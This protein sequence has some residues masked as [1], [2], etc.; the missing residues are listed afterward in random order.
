MASGL[1]D[2]ITESHTGAVATAAALRCG[3]RARTHGTRRRL[4][5]EYLWKLFSRDRSSVQRD[6]A[7]LKT[8]ISLRPPGKLARASPI[9]ESSYRRRSRGLGLGFRLDG[10]RGDLLDDD[11][12]QQL[13]VDQRYAER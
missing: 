10:A 3:G 11:N 6:G 7:K 9:I 4:G 13:R 12:D 2:T 8:G 1:R 5:R